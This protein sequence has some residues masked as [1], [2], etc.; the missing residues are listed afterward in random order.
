[1]VIYKQMTGASNVL[2]KITW[3]SYFAIPQSIYQ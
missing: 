2:L 3:E 1:M